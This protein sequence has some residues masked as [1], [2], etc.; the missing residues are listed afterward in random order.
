MSAAMSSSGHVLVV[1]S[2]NADL[3]MRAPRLP[4]PGET[5][6]GGAFHVAPG[7]KGANQAVAAA[8]L[9]AKVAMIGRVG[10]DAFGMLVRGELERA[11]VCVE[12]VRIDAEAPTGAGQI[13]VDA[14]G[15][16]AIVVASGANARVEVDDVMQAASAWDGAMCVVLQLEIPLVTV[17]ATIAAAHARQ[18]P[19]L[20]NAAPAQVLPDDLMQA[21]SWLVVN[22]VEAEQLAHRTVRSRADAIDVAAGLRNA[23]Q[24]V[25]VTLGANGAVLVSD[26]RT[27][28]VPAL[29]VDVVDTTAA[30]DAFVGALAAALQRGVS[31]GDALRDAVVAGSLACTRAGAIPSL[32]MAAEVDA[33]SRILNALGGHSAGGGQ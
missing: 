17:A 12:H 3:V 2:L 33:Q 15:Q 10:N 25:L 21:V 22:E 31:E 9:G 27:M 30:G 20:L 5:V 24:R 18:I 6:V 11:G 4:R 29:P 16:N 13:V 32:P 7:G 14:T 8:R 28:H 23:G 26:A 19:V 1:G